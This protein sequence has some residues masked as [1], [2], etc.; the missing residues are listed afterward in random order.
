M[1]RPRANSR[2]YKKQATEL[3]KSSFALAWVMDTGTEERERGV[4]VDIAQHHFGTEQANFTILDAPGHRD[5]VP[6]MIA[7]ASMA[8]LAVLVVDAN[9]LE[10][11][12]KGQTREHVLLARA[13][14]LKKMI[15]AVNK[16]DSTLPAAWH[17]ETFDQVSKE[18]SKFLREAGFAVEDVTIVPCSGLT[19]ENVARAGPQ[20]SS[21]SWVVEASPPLLQRLKD[22]IPADPSEV[23]V[24]RPLR[25]QIADVFR[26]SVQNPLSVSGRITSGHVQLGDTVTVLPGG[27][28]ASIKGI[29]VSGEPQDWAVANHICTLHLADIEAQHLRVGDALCHHQHP[30]AVVRSFTARVQAMDTLLPQGVDA[31]AGRLHV[32]GR[33]EKLNAVLDGE[34]SVLRRKPRVV[35]AGEMADIKV[36]LDAGVVLEPGDRV[37]LRS[38]GSSVAFGS[39]L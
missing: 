30:P 9:Q 27:E 25:M 11:G 8:D 13:C 15:V 6:N 33:I 35:K 7:G 21:R 2:R 39:V 28:S 12:M 16:L 31:H 10:S 24:Q 20:D 19:G 1:S 26:G 23:L 18:V 34:G 22:A 37:V 4:T 5:F 36:A 17:R 14:G 29:E 38:G 32:G 3:G